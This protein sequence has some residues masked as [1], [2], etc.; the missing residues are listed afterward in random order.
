MA[1][2]LETEVPTDDELA[3]ML[4]DGEAEATD[5]CP[6]EPDGYCEHE[7]PSWLLKLGFI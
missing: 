2:Y 3:E 6:V 4:F 7:K 1:E 5:G